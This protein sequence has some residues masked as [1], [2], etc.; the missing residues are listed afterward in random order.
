V[1]CP[2]DANAGD[3]GDHAAHLAKLQSRTIDARSDISEADL[4]RQFEMMMS[5][6]AAIMR[7]GNTPP[8]RGC[9]RNRSRP[10]GCRQS[11]ADILPL[12]RYYVVTRSLPSLAK[13]YCFGWLAAVV[14]PVSRREGNRHF[15]DRG[16]HA[17]YLGPSEVSPGHVVYL[18]SSRRITTVAK[19]T[20]S[21]PRSAVM[22]RGAAVAA[23]AAASISQE[24]GWLSRGLPLKAS[25]TE[26]EVKAKPN[27]IGA[28][29]LA[30]ATAVS[31]KRLIADCMAS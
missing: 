15:A 30:A 12:R 17:I 5:E 14:I 26:V 22:V 2:F 20:S 13:L 25:S 1:H 3:G 29:K 8:S 11:T 19:I 27:E 21:S 23:R 9:V 28:C 24:S 7:T 31:A 4:R 18:H 16:E 10:A 6:R